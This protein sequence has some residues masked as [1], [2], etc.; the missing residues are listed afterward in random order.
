MPEIAPAKTT[1]QKPDR[2]ES[3][4]A[5]GVSWAWPEATFNDWSPGCFTC[6]LAWEGVASLAVNHQSADQRPGD[7]QCPVR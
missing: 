6:A 7:S 5:C 1:P 2:L 4:P 3:C